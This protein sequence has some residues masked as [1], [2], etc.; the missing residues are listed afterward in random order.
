MI[1]TLSPAKLLDFERQVDFK[2][3]TIPQFLKGADELYD[4]IK[5]LTVD[6]LAKLM[7]INIKLAQEVHQYL[8]AYWQ[9]Q[10]PQRQAIFA[11]NGIAYKGLDSYTLDEKALE[12][13]QE[14]LVHI[15]GL[16]GPLRPLDLIKPYRL[17]MQTELVNNRGKNLYS[18]W[19]E[20]ISN[21]IAKRL[22]EDDKT[23][24]NLSSNEYS[25]AINK[26]LLPKDTKIITP[27]FK[28]YNGKDY[29]Q[30]TVYAKKARG[31]MTRFIIKNQLTDI[32]HIKA[33]DTEN[34]CFAPQLSNDKEWVFIR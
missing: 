20:T 33:F 11:Y 27:I 30:I 5:H 3:S 10:T 29:K 6:E 32:E 28:E 21:Y 2:E 18:F 31:M 23:W 24:I 22:E 16:Y 19:T 8:H 13:A 15:S 4:S 34:Y 9:P 26:K 14:H 12:F 7:H 1:I 17:E 25:K